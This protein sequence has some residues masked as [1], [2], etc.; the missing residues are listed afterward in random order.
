MG[1]SERK[2]E[3]ARQEALGPFCQV[4]AKREHERH[5]EDVLQRNWL[6][7][8]FG[9]SSSDKADAGVEIQS[10]I[11]KLPVGA[12]RSE[13]E[14]ARDRVV[15]RVKREQE[16]QERIDALVNGGLREIHPYVQTLVEKDRLQLEDGETTYSL[17]EDLKEAV[18]ELLEDE[19]DGRE[20]QEALKKLVHELVREELGI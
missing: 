12:S 3:Q 2:L 7:L 10:A 4:L 8:P 11:A 1:T 16:E 5:C 13:I 9:M 19:L 15:S 17:A 6:H 14:A 18:R 20:S